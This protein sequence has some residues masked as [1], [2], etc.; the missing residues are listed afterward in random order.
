MPPTGPSVDG[1]RFGR[2][3]SLVAAV[4]RRPVPTV[5]VVAAVARLAFALV[6]FV[7]HH[8]GLVDDEAPYLTV[9]SRVA[10]G[11]GAASYRAGYGQD[12]YESRW[13]FLAPLAR[14]AAVFGP[15]RLPGQLLVAAAGTLAVALVALAA[16]R[17]LPPSGVLVAGL[18]VALVPSQVMWSSVVLADAL[19]W[20]ALGAVTWGIVAL[21]TTEVGRGRWRAPLAVLAVAGGLL[22]LGWL[23][24]QTL[25]VAAWAVAVAAIVTGWRRWGVMAGGLALAAVVPLLAGLGPG[26]ASLVVQEVPDLGQTRAR[27]SIGA[28][29]GVEGP[30]PELVLSPELQER[31]A[32]MAEELEARDVASSKV[33]TVT[34]DGRRY[35]VLVDEQGVLYPAREGTAASVRHL[36]AGIAVALLRPYPGEAATSLPSR[37]ASVENLAWYVLYGLAIVGLVRAPPRIRRLLVFPIAFIAFYVAQ[38]AVS[39]GNL[40]TAFRHRGQVLWALA[41]LTAVAVVR[42][43]R[44]PKAEPPT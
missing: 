7:V 32:R 42:P 17:F 22:S 40:G 3:G 5:V 4:S 18:V 13:L 15:T 19:V 26:G 37:L 16:R 25:G 20:A 12:L 44:D 21:V 8:D 9:A 34:I 14:L 10:N 38:A 1:G 23:R 29:S 33:G 39:Q 43:A 41:L 11:R 36:P 31:A 6:S 28:E 27:M 35:T 2:A 24:P 30:S